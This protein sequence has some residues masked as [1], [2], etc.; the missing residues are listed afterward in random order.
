VIVLAAFDDGT[1]KQAFNYVTQLRAAGISAD[2]YPESGKLK[3]QIKYASDI[4]SSYV[5]IIGEEEMKNGTM[6][7]KD[8]VSGDQRS[9]TLMEF[10]EMLNP[11]Q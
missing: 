6:M 3:K 7:L 11:T 2:I 5:G 1:H 4:G 10:V 8:L 9:V